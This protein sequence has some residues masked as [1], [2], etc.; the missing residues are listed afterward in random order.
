MH[1]SVPPLEL[2]RP[3]YAVAYTC[4]L[5]LNAHSCKQ[6]CLEGGT[7]IDGTALL[8]HG[9]LMPDALNCE[10]QLIFVQRLDTVVR[11]KECLQN[12]QVTQM[13]TH[14]VSHEGSSD[15]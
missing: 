8:P 1:L 11:F 4:V 2:S 13:L 15:E 5:V 10:E 6:W 3:I 7:M 12:T 14:L 9:K